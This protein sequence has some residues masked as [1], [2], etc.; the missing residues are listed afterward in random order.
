MINLESGRQ[1]INFFKACKSKQINR[2]TVLARN[3][4]GQK[5]QKFHPRRCSEVIIVGNISVAAPVIKDPDF[6]FQCSTILCLLVFGLHTL[7]LCWQWNFSSFIS[8]VHDQYRK[9]G[10]GSYYYTCPFYQKS[11][12]F[13][14][15]CLIT[16]YISLLKHGSYGHF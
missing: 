8:E 6:L 3:V 12:I 14:G 4:F 5:K 1:N 11:K 15:D 7:T 16:L 2:P 10:N 13:L 9:K